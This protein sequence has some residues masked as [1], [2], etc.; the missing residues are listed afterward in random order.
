MLNELYIKLWIFLNLF[1]YF[2]CIIKIRKYRISFEACGL[3]GPTIWS[4]HLGSAVPVIRYEPQNFVMG[5][6]I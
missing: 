4:R 2:I 5:H 6:M 3:V 1:F